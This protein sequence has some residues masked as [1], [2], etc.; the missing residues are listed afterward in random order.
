MSALSIFLGNIR[1]LATAT[2]IA[3]AVEW[4]QEQIHSNLLS[5]DSAKT[6]NDD[7]TRFRAV[8]AKSEMMFI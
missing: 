3:G 4:A 1:G 6:L 7:T 8:N 5:A 2:W